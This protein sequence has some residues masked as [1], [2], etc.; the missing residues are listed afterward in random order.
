MS[1][2]RILAFM[3]SATLAVLAAAT[4][5]AQG[6]GFGLV[7]NTPH[8]LSVS[9]PGGVRATAESEIC[10]FCHTPH[11]AAVGPGALWNRVDAPTTYQIYRSSSLKATIGQPTGTSKLCLSCHDGTVALGQLRSRS[12]LVAFQHAGGKMPPGR[13]NLGTDL[14]DDH[15][16]SFPYSSS[17]SGGNTKL[18]PPTAIV[19]PVTLDENGELQCSSCHTVHDN[20]H[21]NFLVSPDDAGALCLSCHSDPS[22]PASDHATSGIPV[23][24]NVA[25]ALGAD[26]GSVAANACKNCHRPHGA[27]RPSWILHL[28]NSSA[29]CLDCHDGAVASRN[30]AAEIRKFSNHGIDPAAPVGGVSQPFIEGNRVSC[31]DC[32]DPHAAGGAAAGNAPRSL[33]GVE[34]VSLQGVT[35][36]AVTGDHELCFRCHGDNPVAVPSQIDRVAFQPNKRL[37]FQSS[38]PSFHPVGNQG[39]S[40]SVPSLIPPLLPSTRITCGDCH[41]SDRSQRAG[42][43]GPAGPHGSMFAPLL[44]RRYDTV[45]FGRESAA[46]YALCYSCHDRNSIRADESFR[47]HRKH[48]EAA[49][50]PCSV[51]HDPHGISS[52]QGNAMNH[53]HLINFDRSVVFP[54]SSGRLEFEDRGTFQGRCYLTCH[55]VDHDPLEY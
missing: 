19:P 35:V 48:I 30:V 46:A 20:T 4:A 40:S 50:T 21:G 49:Q 6:R 12:Q 36:D 41:D 27:G 10:V 8:N 44:V 34:G 33:A 45:D 24:N 11:G 32:H 55:G 47:E 42:G 5:S 52:A 29:L 15:P 17:I 39:V 28:E 22:W 1:M 53:S 43:T 51:C 37:Q 25:A 18:L 13:A 26:R 7:K 14:S 23:P 54:S 3:T 9:G 2:S 31:P 16:I 38:N